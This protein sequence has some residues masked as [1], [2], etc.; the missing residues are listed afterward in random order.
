[1]TKIELVTAIMEKTEGYKKTHLVEKPKE[2]LET[3]YAQL[4]D[5]ADAAPI[6]DAQDSHEP[7]APPETVAVVAEQTV[8]NAEE[9][10]AKKV[11]PKKVKEEK[12]SN[13]EKALLD[14]IP[15]LPDFKGIESVIEG[16]LLLKAAAGLHDL[17]VKSGAPVFV[18]LKNKGYYTV[19]GKKSGQKKA[20]FQLTEKGMQY[21]KDNN[22][23]PGDAQPAKFNANEWLED[24]K[25]DYGEVTSEMLDDL[26]KT[27][28]LTTVQA[29]E[30]YDLCA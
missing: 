1:M 11:R 24:L 28:L 7:V 26:V 19:K 5:T 14:T 30:I 8:E 29:E 15:T 6:G 22:L 27:G 12:M 2:E 13:K 9:A 3:I 20:T 16:K 21:L 4:A 25:A 10:P 23:L 17:P 18:S